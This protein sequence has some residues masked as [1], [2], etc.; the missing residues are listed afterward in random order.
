MAK[1]IITGT[2]RGIG[3][4]LAKQAA[5]A[6]HQVIALSR[7]AAPI[8]ELKLDKL[9][10]FEFDISDDQSIQQLVNFV[11][12]KWDSK[13]DILINNAGALVNKSF[14]ETELEDYLKVYQVNVFGPAALTKAVLPFMNSDSNV[15]NISSIGGVQGSL[16]FPG[17]AAY[18]SS[19]GAIITLTELLAEEYK[20]KG[21]NFNVMALGAVNTEMLQEA[22]PGYNP[23]TTPAMMAEYLL[24]FV[25]HRAHLFNGKIIEVSNS[26]P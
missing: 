14:E 16:K 13:V 24:D 19:K 12:N 9:S 22:F 20:D 25:L 18:S 1:I 15:L 10:A 17:L 5:A 8:R 23:P 2:S 6:N 11:E 26:T 4:E 7:N 21:P 3:F